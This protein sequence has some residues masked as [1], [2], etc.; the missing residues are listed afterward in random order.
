MKSIYIIALSLIVLSSCATTKPQVVQPPQERAPSQEATN[1][2]LKEYWL[3]ISGQTYVKEM[4]N[5]KAKCTD[6]LNDVKSKIAEAK[7]QPDEDVRIARLKIRDGIIDF[8][9]DY[10]VINKIGQVKRL[11]KKLDYP[12]ISVSTEEHNQACAVAYK[13]IALDAKS[14]AGVDQKIKTEIENSCS[15][16]VGYQKDL[17]LRAEIYEANK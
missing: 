7:G 6:A 14:P 1:S 11:K 10:A 9:C 13:Q 16:L 12:W 2:W 8:N 5:N 15:L 3:E 4:K 17:K